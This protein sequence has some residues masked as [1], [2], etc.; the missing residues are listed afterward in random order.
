MKAWSLLMALA[1]LT[2]FTACAADAPSEEELAKIRDAAPEKPT[3]QPEQPRQ[4]L[5]FSLVPT[6]YV[7]SAIPYGKAAVQAI[8]EKTGAFEVTI[9]DDIAVFE[10]ESL[11]RF[12]AVFFNNANNELFLPPDFNELED[13]AKKEAL[14]RDARLKQSLAGFIQGGK[15]VGL[16][17]AALATFREWEEWGDIVGGRFDNHPWNKEVTLRVDDPD[18]PLTAAFPEPAFK[19]T[20]EIYQVTGPYS[21]ETHRVLLSLDY[22]SAGEANAG[23]VNRED[24]DF[25]LAWVKPYGEGRVFYCGLGHYHELFW[26]PQVLRFLLDG[27]QFTLGDLDADMTP[28][29]KL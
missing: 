9:T 18:H 11:A 27:I 13:T 24:K 4:L 28:S 6:G 12:D 23:E 25:A 14:A 7:H 2:C 10:P 22:E 26:D 21:R 29:A 8:A 5:V 19:I 17:H 3:V 15:G 16:L 20:D 1:I